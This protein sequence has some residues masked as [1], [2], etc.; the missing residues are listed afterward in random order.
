MQAAVV[1]ARLGRNEAARD[2]T[3]TALR[4]GH[5]LGLLRSLLD[6]NPGTADLIR[7]VLADEHND[8][9]LA[10]YG[11][12][13]EVA[14]RSSACVPV[15]RATARN[16]PRRPEVLSERETEVVRLLS[17]ALPNKKIA[18]T[19][20]L[21]PETVKW[22]LKNIYGKLGVSSR[23]QAVARVRDFELGCAP[24]EATR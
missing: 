18:R 10:F 3:L 9:V 11:A 14:A 24:R 5:R 4:R 20:G 2:G 16:D 17:Q 15:E 7:C 21:S 12:R 6:A 8:P 13:I 22:H 1:A 23:D 19:L